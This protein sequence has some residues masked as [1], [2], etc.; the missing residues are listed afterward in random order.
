[1]FRPASSRNMASS[2]HGGERAPPAAA[3]AF[4]HGHAGSG[5]D[6]A[7]AEL[8][9]GSKAWHRRAPNDWVLVELRER[10]AAAG[11]WTVAVVGGGG[12]RRSSSVAAAD[13]QAVPDALL[14]PANPDLQAGQSDLTQL[15]YLNEPSILGMLADRYREDAIYTAAGPVLIAVNPCKPCEAAGLYSC[16][17][18]ERYR[19]AAREAAHGLPPH[20]YSVA[21]SAYRA[22]VREDQPQSII[23]NGESG[24]GKTETTKKAMQFLAALAGGGGGAGGAA[25]AAA[26]TGTAAGQQQQ[27][28]QQ[29]LQQHHQAQRV[30]DSN[31]ILEAFGNAKTLR[32][33]NSSRFGKLI[34][35][36][37]GAAGAGAAGA[38]MPRLTGAKVRTYLLE[39]S[40]VAHRLAGERSFHVFYQLV[41][42]ATAAQRREW[43]LPSGPSG[44]AYL[45]SS[46]CDAIAGVDDAADF[47]AVVAAMD[48]VGIDEGQRSSLFRLVSGVMWLGNLSIEPS[49]RDDGCKLRRDA[50]LVSA[51]AL[52][53][54][55]DDHLALAV[56]TRKIRTPDELIVKLLDA[57]GA[58]DARDALAKAVYAGLFSWVVARI[59]DALD[60]H[61]R[62]CGSHGGAASAPAPAAPAASPTSSS[63]AP[64]RCISILDI[65][66]FEHFGVNSFEQLCINYAN[67]RLQQ[68]FSRHLFTL[69]QQE[70]EQEALE[71]WERVE[72]VDNGAALDVIEAAP[73]RGLGVLSVLDAQCRF[74]KASDETLLVALRDALQGHGSFALDPRRPGEFA[75]AHYAGPVSYAAAGFLEKNRD[76][77]SSDL[78]EL[79][80]GSAHPLLAR[81]GAEAGEVAGNSGG[82][83]GGGGGNGG[84]N[85]GPAGQGAGGAGLQTVSTRFSGQ[86]RELV[87]MLDQGGLHFVRCIK[88]NAALAADTY[89]SDLVLQQLRACGVLEVAR[90]SRAGFPTRYPHAQFVDRYRTLL[91]P[92]Q[93]QET[94]AL[95]QAA[96]GMGGGGGKR[97]GVQG[98]GGAAAAAEALLAAFGVPKGKYEIGRT[99]VFFRPG[100]LGY[101]EDRWAKM[102][103]SVVTLQSGARMWA[104]RRRLLRAREAASAL[105]A[106]WRGVL[107]QRAYREDLA[108]HRAAVAVQAAWRGRAARAERARRMHAV[109]A[110]QCAVR[111]RQLDAR[112]AA[113][114]RARLEREAS[115]RERDAERRRAQE[116]F[117]AV[118]S[119]FGVRDLGEVRA[120]LGSYAAVRD[121][122]LIAALTGAGS[123]AGG[124]GAA[125]AASPVDVDGAIREMRAAAA[126][127]A[128]AQAE[129]L[130]S[131][132]T[133]GRQ[134]PSPEALQEEVLRALRLSSALQQ[135]QIGAPT[136]TATAAA[137]EPD[138]EEIAKAAALGSAARS[139]GVTD[140]EQLQAALALAMAASRARGGVTD[141]SEYERLEA[142]SLEA[143]RSAEEQLREA[144]GRAEGDG[145]SASAAAAAAAATA[146]AAL[147]LAHKERDAVRAEAD[148]ARRAAADAE[149]RLAAEDSQRAAVAAAAGVAEDSQRA[150]AEAAAAAAEAE[151]SRLRAS[152]AEL[153]AEREAEAEAKRKADDEALVGAREQREADAQKASIAAAAAAASAAAALA[154]ARE[155]RDALRAESA[156]ALEAAAAEREAAV[157][158][159]EAR[160]AQSAADASAKDAELLA[161]REMMAASREAG[162]ADAQQLRLALAVHAAAASA[163]GAGQVDPRAVRRALSMFAAARQAGLS[164]KRDFMTAA[165]LYGVLREEELTS[166]ADVRAAAALYA[167]VR[168]EGVSDPAQLQAAV[169]AAA[170][171]AAGAAGAGP[172]ADGLLLLRATDD[173]SADDAARLRQRL[174]AERAARQR[175]AAQ[176]EE[177]AA[178]FM[179]QVT[180]LKRCI[181]GLRARLNDEAADRQTAPGAPPPP[182]SDGGSSAFFFQP[183]ASGDA[184]AELEALR[185]KHDDWNAAFE[186]RLREAEAAVSLEQH[187]QRGAAGATA[188]L[189]ASSVAA[190]GGRA[191]GKH[192]GVAQMPDLRA[193][194]PA[195]TGTGSDA[196]DDP[197]GADEAG[198]GAAQT[199]PPPHPAQ[200]TPSTQQKR[201]LFGRLRG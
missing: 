127:R 134:A 40:R 12:G 90:V 151:V 182:P 147:A 120:A 121:A 44:W 128:A 95:Q 5:L 146:A 158:A 118:K 7:V 10:D 70:Y 144:R 38:Q 178:E 123:G 180:A 189:S 161:A 131:R 19:A 100:V 176:L 125:P 137:A 69:E 30:L 129:F 112:V 73:P 190:L 36:H 168:E 99:K 91:S 171:G 8:E 37:F 172:G 132:A 67:E 166:A 153:A 82:N 152:L 119:E 195:T 101:V 198:G 56:T 135:Q 185:R 26:A 48:D 53:G 80:A 14:A 4:T 154:L 179:G 160:G 113:R 94:L 130:L 64:R 156:A 16:E 149:A 33:H 6:D 28:H 110:A 186:Q 117:E 183:A 191:G 59:N 29:P 49:D 23:I 126:L 57:D 188:T 173:G 164:E 177:Q 46:G 85:G 66:G 52:L 63:A 88:P 11:T 60:E 96:G 71:G 74:P 106:R 105:Q 25:A 17:A 141:A 61:A 196:W 201:G 163:L 18:V 109:R 77:L 92:R 175:Y 72:W 98:G 169:T 170:A 200:T 21:G 9:R 133:G 84:G 104:A 65:Y 108:C 116:G 39:K 199:T 54:V 51:A 1:M 165:L 50:A 187:Q 31:P 122:G 115:E 103:A 22:M 79:M 47:A 143:R 15:S 3:A 78:I 111:R 148:E 102:Q 35:I 140:A 145:R 45:A 181:D 24:A 87:A 81:I 93:Q 194:A 32:N 114:S 97:G 159:A 193:A 68:Q 13:E 41:R 27:Q 75:L 58:R 157:R 184:V 89:A 162:V 174:I 139:F 76:T 34:E 2:G 43:G 20:I 42:G 138:P 62:T 136:T 124:A 150:R 86:L 107:A 142:E 83:G 197:Y 192:A 155:E 55:T 167:A